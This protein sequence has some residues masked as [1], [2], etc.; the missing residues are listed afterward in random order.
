MRV[1]YIAAGAA[2]MICGSCLR[3]NALARELRAIGCEVT[4]VPVYTPI[5]TEENDESED[6][7][8]FGGVSVYLEQKS[9]VF[10]MLPRAALKWLD[11]PSFVRRVTEKRSI[12]VEAQS[13]G[14]LTLSMLRGENGNQKKEVELAVEWLTS[15]EP[16]DLLNLTNLLIAGFVPSLKHKLS[17]PVLVTLQGDDLFLNELTDE[18]RREV[19]IE[20]RR[21]AAEIDG[22]ITFSKDYVEVMA[23]L[24]DVSPDK[25]HLVPLGINAADFAKLERSPERPP[26]IGYFGRIAP[27]KGFGLIVDAF[28]ALHQS[29]EHPEARLT[30]GGWLGEGDQAFFDEQIAKLKSANVYAKFQHIGS[31]DREGKLAFFESIDLFSMPAQQR[32][33]KGLSVLEAM[34]SGLPV[35]QPDHGIFP[36][37]I[38]DQA[39][40]LLFPAGDAKALAER[41]SSL[42][43]DP[44][45]AQKIGAKA[46]NTI[47]AH[48]TDRGMAKAT[49]EIY[50]Q[51]TTK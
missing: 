9:K 48:R 1:T 4:F 50:T 32:E 6:A 22:F 15:N 31:P 46:R 36:E 11:R 14:E 45:R 26:T 43:S 25:F 3:D 18:H 24:L 41:I 20:L 40:G 16:P 2:G 7:L 30:A 19:L 44:I 35:V 51:F 37:I 39:D 27:E 21:L 10:R 13:L 49:M 5:T 47:R 28:I 33:P 38:T 12:D 17:L 29:G 34:A 8:L 23:E 42:L